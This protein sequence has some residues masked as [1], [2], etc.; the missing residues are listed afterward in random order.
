LT[1]EKYE[2]TST[3]NYLRAF[4]LLEQGDPAAIAAFAGVAAERPDDPLAGFHLRRLLNGAAGVR[5]AMG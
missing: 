3:Q 2:S 4:A 5:I 1:Q